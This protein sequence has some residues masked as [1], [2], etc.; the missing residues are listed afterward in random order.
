MSER[1][2]SIVTGRPSAWHATRSANSWSPDPATTNDGSGWLRWRIA[3]T[4]ANA[5]GP[6]DP[7][8]RP[9]TQTMRTSSWK[10]QVSPRR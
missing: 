10:A 1:Q 6:L 3:A 4:S 9:I 8:S 2:P 5:V 7:V